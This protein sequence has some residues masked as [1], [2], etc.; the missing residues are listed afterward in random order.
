MR[1]QSTSYHQQADTF[2]PPLPWSVKWGWGTGSLGTVT[3]LYL[4]SSLVLFYMTNYLGINAALAGSLLFMTRLYDL[5]SD[6]IM[7]LVSDNTKTSW[8]RRRPWLFIGAILC[9]LSC[10]LLFSG[11][12]IVSS[13]YA[14]TY[15]VIVIVLYFTG[16]TMF[17][18]PYLAMPAEMT[19]DKHERTSLMSARVFF[20]A[21]AGIVATGLAP[22]L[23]S[24][25]GDGILG[26]AWMSWIIAAMIGIAMFLPVWATR[27][28]PQTTQHRF[29]VEWQ[30]WIQTAWQ[31]R[32]FKM[33]IGAKLLQLFGLASGSATLFFFVLQVLDRGMLG[34]SLYG[35]A[36]SI[37]TILSLP[38]WTK[39]GHHTSKASLYGLAV[40]GYAVLMLSWL[41][42]DPAESTSL[43]I[44]R[45]CLA[46]MFSG[47]LILMGQSLL[48]DTISYDYHLTGLRREAAFASVYSAAEKFSFAFSPLILGALLSM[49]G[50]QE[51]TEGDIEQ[52]PQ[53]IRAVYIGMAIIPALAN[54]SSLYF[55]RHIQ[56][57]TPQ[58]ESTQS[59]KEGA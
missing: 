14:A 58:T 18:V 59:L 12:L 40:F 15:M 13:T 31:N 32:P 27:D 56:F 44:L 8:G 1:A 55:I 2:R 11:A 42:A 34:V 22:L 30:S 35:F 10:A 16:Y 4:F 50:Y 57:E 43:F 47:G 20:V 41:L 24:A 28:A 5:I 46:G 52:T 36:M 7:G 26:Y 33:L 3:L 39:L 19:E 38:L 29:Q 17:N 45:S 37:G 6:P 53:A 21:L 25:F 9:A 23:I 48:P 49:M 51:S 54:L